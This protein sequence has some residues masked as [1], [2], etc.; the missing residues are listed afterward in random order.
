MLCYWA[1]FL[2]YAESLLIGDST[3]VVPD[4]TEAIARHLAN[5]F[6]GA[7][8]LPI[9]RFFEAIARPCPVLELGE[10]RSIVEKRMTT[11]RVP[12]ML[13]SATCLALW[14]LESRGT[15]KLSHASDAET[16][17]LPPSVSSASAGAGT[18]RTVSHIEYHV[19]T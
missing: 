9:A 5:V 8:K 12:K 1:R 15:L 4:P 14:R 17:L 6:E 18:V 11:P 10:T 13:S 16:W 19:R 2:G 7:P 3:V